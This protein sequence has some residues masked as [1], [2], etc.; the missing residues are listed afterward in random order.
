MAPCIRLGR[1]RGTSRVRRNEG[2]G[3]SSFPAQRATFGDVLAVREFRTLWL[4]QSLSEVG[5]RLALVAL[6]LLV[7]DRTGSPLLAAVAYA[8]GYVPWVIGGLIFS[9]LGDRLPRREVMVACDVIRAL[10]VAVMLLPGMPVAGLVG[11]LYVTTMAQAPFE[12]ARS[13][14]LPDILPGDRYALAATVMQTSFRVAMV[15]GAAIGG[16]TIALIGTRTAL[17]VDVATFLAS[18]VLVRFGTRSR[19]AAAGPGPGALKQLGEGARLVLGDKAIRTLMMLGWLI[20]LYSIPEGIAAPYVGRL[21]GGPAAA[22]LVIAS[23]QVGAVLAAPLFTR[24]VGPLTR[25][26]WM[27]PMAV[28]TCAVL[29]LTLFRPDLAISMA[30]FALSGTFAIYQIAANTA[31]VEWVPDTRRAQAFGLANMGTVLGQG[32]ALTI[33]GAAAEVMS[34]STVI[35]IGGGLG[36]LTA[37]ALAL[38]WRH[39]SPAVGRHSARHLRGCQAG[40]AG[41]EPPADLDAH[42]LSGTQ[43]GQ[44]LYPP[45]QA[46]PIARPAA[47]PATEPTARPAT[48]TAPRPAYV[49]TRRIAT[50][51]IDMPSDA[52]VPVPRVPEL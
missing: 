6:T 19:P 18:A 45:R 30:I 13:A 37:C 12:S 43:A 36:A 39:I 46:R 25:L 27:G 49:G 41:P 50:V 14:I 8:A 26:R 1:L 21:G 2:V 52:P 4:S 31:F 42:R 20:A 32:A 10:L 7:Y 11:L 40:F 24:T 17:G 51:L 34:P 9:G 22:G 29:S 5:D 35:A 28:C 33:A 47:R 23:G 48:G 44:P 38:R 3:V 15:A 16:V